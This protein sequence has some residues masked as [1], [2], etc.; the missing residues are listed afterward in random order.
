VCA[1]Y[2]VVGEERFVH[3]WNAVDS[4]QFVCTISLHST[5]GFPLAVSKTCSLLA[6]ASTI[7]TALKVYIVVVCNHLTPI[8]VLSDLNLC[9]H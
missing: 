1:Q 5:A 3:V 4:L 2:V 7:H 8:N 6:T 9:A